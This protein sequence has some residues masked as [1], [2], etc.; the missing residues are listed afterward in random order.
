MGCGSKLWY[1]Q[2]RYLNT[3]RKKEK[4]RKGKLGEKEIIGNTILH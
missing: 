1:L 3:T 4:E 2:C